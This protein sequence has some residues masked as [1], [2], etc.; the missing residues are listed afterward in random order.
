MAEY[1]EVEFIPADWVSRAAFWPG[2]EVLSRPVSIPVGTVCPQRRKT[3]R[4]TPISTV[5][6]LPESPEAILDLMERLLEAYDERALLGKIAG[7]SPARR[8]FRAEAG[9]LSLSHE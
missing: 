3:D 2:L 6:Q 7:S 9:R 1:R 4:D 8:S 5:E